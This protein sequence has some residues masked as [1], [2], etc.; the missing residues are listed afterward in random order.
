MLRD[1]KTDDVR[2]LDVRKRDCDFTDEF[3]IATARSKL[4]AQTAA[5]A[6]VYQVCLQYYLFH[7]IIAPSISFC[8][9]GIEVSNEKRG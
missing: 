8:P 2:V 7:D 6:I 9:L 1:A 3:V 4:H 5:Q